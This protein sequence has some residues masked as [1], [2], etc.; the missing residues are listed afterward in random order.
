[1]KRAPL[2]S[3]KVPAR[4]RRLFEFNQPIPTPEV[5]GLG[6]AIWLIFFAVWELASWLGWAPEFL[7][8]PPQTV[9]ITLYS[10]IVHQ[11]FFT[12]IGI[13][14][15]RIL[16][17]FAIACAVAIP[18]GILMGS[19]RRVEAFFN[20]LVSAWRYL[21]APSFIPLI[22]MWMGTGDLSKLTLLFIGIIWFLITLVM[23]HTKS[24]SRDFIDTARTL[25]ASRRQILLTVIVPAVMPNLFVTMRQMMAAAWTYLVIAEIIAATTGIGAMMMRAKKFLHVD[26]IMA[27]IVVIGILGLLFDYIFRVAHRRLFHY[28]EQRSA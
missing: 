23:D 27:G 10:L 4:R 6:I 1:M 20:P 19:F 25:G 2:G 16:A 26:Q 28:E 12:D 7:F 24:V 22:V 11:D 15:Y 18:L 14:V 17:S 3:R 5:I 21:P 9:V 13:S 8:P